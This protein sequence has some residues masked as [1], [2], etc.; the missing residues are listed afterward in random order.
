MLAPL[1]FFQLNS[2]MIY[3][4]QSPKRKPT[5]PTQIWYGTKSVYQRPTLQ[6]TARA[7]GLRPYS[8]TLQGAGGR[9]GV[10]LKLKP[11]AIAG[12]PLQV[13]PIAPFYH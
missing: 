8:P 6:S 9:A 2:W 10:G 4:L 12:P 7:G 1:H 3:I 13:V 11:L 5:V